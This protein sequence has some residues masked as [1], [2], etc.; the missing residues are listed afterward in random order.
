MK[1]KQIKQIVSTVSVPAE[2]ILQSGIR[3]KF[4][5]LHLLAPGSQQL[6]PNLKD[7]VLTCRME[8]AAW[9]L[10]GYVKGSRHTRLSVRES[11]K[12]IPCPHFCLPTIHYLD[13][14]LV[15]QTQ[16]QAPVSL[17]GLPLEQSCF[18]VSS[19]SVFCI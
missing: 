19:L 10:L 4:P 16:V 15:T 2:R 13:T 5:A 1:G 11:L 7:L 6:S 18:D 14:P 12:Q 8:D 3:V 9:R 17:S